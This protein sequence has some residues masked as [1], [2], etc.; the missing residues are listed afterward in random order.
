MNITEV[1]SLNGAVTFMYAM[2]SPIVVIPSRPRGWRVFDYKGD[3]PCIP[4]K[5]MREIAR[6]LAGKKEVA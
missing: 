5:A 6:R 2:P 4:V 3:K 1:G